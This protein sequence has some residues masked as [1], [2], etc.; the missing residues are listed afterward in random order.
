MDSAI[1]Q[2]PFTWLE[3]L[4]SYVGQKNQVCFNYPKINLETM[5]ENF[6]S[7][8]P[9]I[10]LTS[11]DLELLDFPGSKERIPDENSKFIEFPWKF[12]PSLEPVNDLTHTFYTSG[13]ESQISPT[14]TIRALNVLLFD[15]FGKPLYVGAPYSFHSTS[16]ENLLNP[17]Q[18]LYS[19]TEFIE[20][21][22]NLEIPNFET[23]D[24]WMNF[25]I[26]FDKLINN[27]TLFQRFKM[28]IVYSKLF[29]GMFPNDPIDA[30][31]TIHFVHLFQKMKDCIDEEHPHLT[32][33]KFIMKQDGFGKAALKYDTE[34]IFRLAENNK[35]ALEALLEY[36]ETGN[37]RYKEVLL[38]RDCLHLL[39]LKILVGLYF[40]ICSI[41]KRT[42]NK[43]Q[44]WKHFYTLTK[45]TQTLFDDIIKILKDLGDQKL[46]FSI[47]KM[48]LS[49]HNFTAFALQLSHKSFLN[50]IF[51]E[52]LNQPELKLF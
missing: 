29:D 35:D 33:L 43:K 38:L 24:A 12:G 52:L 8:I 19:K 9:T 36:H 48:I 23:S 46:N 30:G 32:N 20:E 1:V 42:G 44:R 15:F 26:V 28:M 47:A 10:C 41:V 39:P 37:V 27:M 6:E 50:E 11:P 51:E 49:T 17:L 14:H 13:I 40:I 18:E 21:I 16:G 25:W 31:P 2:L 5:V 7:V 34:N 45:S 22:N 4:K 3:K